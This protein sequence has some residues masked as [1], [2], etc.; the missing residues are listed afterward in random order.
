MSLIPLITINEINRLHT[1][2]RA[3]AADAIEYA[4]QAGLHLLSVKE[5]QPHG[6]FGK[7]LEANVNVSQRQAQ[8]YMAAAQGKAVSMAD[9][10]VKYDTVSHL[11]Q[12]ESTSQVVLKDRWMPKVGYIYLF[13]DAEGS[14]YWVTPSIEPAGGFH[15]CKHYSGERLSSKDFFPQYTILSEVH[16]EDLTSQYYIGTRRPLAMK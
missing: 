9:L 1:L 11:T 12:P 3:T 15:I 6:E 2:A 7:W 5:T 13:N 16:D 8:R 4:R 10:T 14:V